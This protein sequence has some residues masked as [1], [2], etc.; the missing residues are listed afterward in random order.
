V[1]YST[2]IYILVCTT[3]SLSLVACN[4]RLSGGAPVSGSLSA[5]GGGGGTQQV[6][7]RTMNTQLDLL[8][9]IDDSGFQ[10]GPQSILTGSLGPTYSYLASQGWDLHMAVVGTD[11]YMA[12]PLLANYN[13]VN[14]PLA[15]FKSPSSNFI[16]TQNTLNLS[17][18]FDA[19]LSIG[20]TG[21]NDDR[22][23]SSFRTALNSSLNSGFLRSTSFLGIFILSDQDDFS[24]NGRGS[25]VIPQHSYSDPNLE[26][27]SVYTSY[28]DGLTGTTGN[29]RRYSV[30]A[31]D[32][33]DNTCLTTRLMTNVYAIIGMRYSQLAASTNGVIGDLCDSDYT[34][35]MATI[36]NQWAILATQIFVTVPPSNLNVVNVTVNGVTVNQDPANGWTFNTNSNSFQ[37]H[38]TSIP[39][40]GAAIN[41]TYM[42]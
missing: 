21:N 6:I 24:G 33:P 34:P 35:D 28:L 19:N 13:S 31:I 32:V 16:V 14:A 20:Q 22:A 5:G 18:V 1:R 27:L 3:L 15:Q 38:G 39:K 2:W 11:A 29:S 37:F 42:P 8:W 7:I 25:D 36:S 17:S 4:N 23:F 30:S 40:Y 12:D 10:A 41:I 26:P 9:V